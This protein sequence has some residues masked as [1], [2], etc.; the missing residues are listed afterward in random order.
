[1]LALTM[2]GLWAEWADP[3]TVPYCAGSNLPTLYL[4]APK[5]IDINRQTKQITVI[6]IPKCKSFLVGIN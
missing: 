6:G 4:E 2:G 5:N 1:M 3:V